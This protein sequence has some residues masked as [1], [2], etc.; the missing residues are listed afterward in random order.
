MIDQPA[1]QATD[2]V[3]Y[4]IVRYEQYIIVYHQADGQ[5]IGNLSK[6]KYP[7]LQISHGVGQTR[8]LAKGMAVARLLDALKALSRRTRLITY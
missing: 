3:E 6:A 8:E 7:E 5:W 1:E 4:V 2:L